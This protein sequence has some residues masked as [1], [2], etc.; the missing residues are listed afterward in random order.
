[1]KPA[2]FCREIEAV[3][4]AGRVP[5]VRLY[6]GADP[7]KS[8]MRRR[9]LVGPATATLLPRGTDPLDLHWPACPMVADVTRLDCATVRKLAEALV[10][11]GC[12]LAFLTDLNAAIT[13]RIVPVAEVA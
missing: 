11:D 1:M 4:A 2:P 13:H 9:A 10:R 12:E 3:I 6:A 8:C 5:D 7:W